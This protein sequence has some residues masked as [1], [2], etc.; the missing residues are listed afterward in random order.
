[1]DTIEKTVHT[2]EAT[3]EVHREPIRQNHAV[4][5]KSGF[6]AFRAAPT[7]ASDADEV[8]ACPLGCQSRTVSKSLVLLR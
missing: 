5:F 8:P 3:I 7:Q 1:M 4:S 2:F 6:I